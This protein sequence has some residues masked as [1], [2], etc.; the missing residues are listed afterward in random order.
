VVQLREVTGSL[1][2]FSTSFVE[3]PA[4]ARVIGKER[5]GTLFKCLIVLALEH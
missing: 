2:G 4:I 5:K 1:L 3:R